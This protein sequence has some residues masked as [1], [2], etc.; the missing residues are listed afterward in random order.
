MNI[1]GVQDK[2]FRPLDGESISKR[3]NYWCQF[4][5]TINGFRPLDG[6]SISKPYPCKPCKFQG[7]RGTFRAKNLTS[8]F[9]P[10]NQVKI[11]P[12][13]PKSTILSH[14]GKMEFSSIALVSIT[15]KK[16]FANTLF[17]HKFYKNKKMRASCPLIFF[18]FP[19]AHLFTNTTYIEIR[20]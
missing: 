9:L 10:L 8:A 14:R 6:E 15:Q 16:A 18:A 20:S 5:S 2:G 7:L 19:H 12:H 1:C 17:C 4:V 11:N 13:T 3:I